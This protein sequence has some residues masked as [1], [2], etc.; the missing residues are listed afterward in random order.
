MLRSAVR[1]QEHTG[2]RVG[3]AHTEVLLAQ[4]EEGSN[5]L[6][7]VPL[8]WPASVDG[9]LPVSRGMQ[10]PA[11]GRRPARCWGKEDANSQK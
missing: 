5:S 7:H 2:G 3:E 9:E 8:A 4:C 11:G 10:A 1:K 6:S